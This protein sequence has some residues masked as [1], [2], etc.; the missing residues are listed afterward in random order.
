MGW[1]GGGRKDKKDGRKVGR[2]E[3]G[4]PVVATKRR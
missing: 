4:V 1:D 3:G 2:R